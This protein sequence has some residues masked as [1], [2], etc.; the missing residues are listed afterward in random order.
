MTAPAS[1]TVV[2]LGH[3]PGRDERT[4]THVALVARAFGADRVIVPDSA[5][6]VTETVADIA[7][8]FGGEGFDIDEVQN[9]L[10]WLERCDEPI[11]HLTMY[12]LPV[13]E[14]VDDVQAHTNAGSL[15]IA[16][17]GGKVPGDLYEW[18]T[19][20]VA[21]TNQPHSEIA[22]LAVFMDRLTDGSALETT[23][24]DGAY[25]VIPTESG[26]HVE[27]DTEE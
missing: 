26:K 27:Q 13:Q 18:A 16:V 4:T 19:W 20:N 23:W 11:C 25:E 21:I 12:G 6:H 7:T 14:L 5:G 9:P 17:G 10:Q 2:R 1:V 15:T 22:A 8:R 24:E 3:R